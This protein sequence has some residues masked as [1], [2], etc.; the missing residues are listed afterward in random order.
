MSDKVIQAFPSK[1]LPECPV[2]VDR[3]PMRH[4]NHQRIRLVEHD[5]A[6][7][8]QDCGATLDPFRY[9]LDGAHAMRHGWQEYR[10][11]QQLLKEKREQ[12][13]ALE[14]ER[15]RLAGQVRRLKGKVEGDVLD[16]RKPL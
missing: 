3:G 10:Y 7:L 8:C 2:D 15:K 6:L 14:K 9:L 11:V 12:L 4:C 5:R 16:M 1:D 13:A